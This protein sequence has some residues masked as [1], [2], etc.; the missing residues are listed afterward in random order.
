MGV[1]EHNDYYDMMHTLK[2]VADGATIKAT[3]CQMN[4]NKIDCTIEVIR[5]DTFK[6]TSLEGN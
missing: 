1:N 3:K 2:K 6:S 5:G 4:K